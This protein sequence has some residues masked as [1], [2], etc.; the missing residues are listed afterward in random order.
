MHELVAIW[1]ERKGLAWIGATAFIYAL[2]LIPFNQLALTVAGI[3]IRP[4]AALPVLFGILFGPAS[5]W[6]LAIGNIA[7]DLYGSWSPMS[8]FG[9]ITNF[10]APY[11]SY[12]LWH[13]LMRGQEIKVNRVSTGFYLL[14]SFV[15]IFSCM[16]LLAGC[17][18]AFFSRPFASKF[19]SYFG[20][21]IAWALTAGLVLF[22]LV[23]EPAARNGYVYGREWA[24]RKTPN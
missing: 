21:N 20:N 19:I 17:G 14:V 4:A 11:L 12:L 22:W 23:L 15:V 2:V 9:F 10:I 7:G 13:R 24:R 18:T 1:T 6:G 5:S 16:L 8:I 3:S